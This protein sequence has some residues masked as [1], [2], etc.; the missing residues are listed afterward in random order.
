MNRRLV[1]LADRQ[2]RFGQFGANLG[3]IAFGERENLFIQLHH[4][5]VVF[6]GFAL[7]DGAFQVAPFCHAQVALGKHIA[8]ALFNFKAAE[9]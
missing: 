8:Q 3:G 4:A 2:A 7:D 5:G 6:G 1:G 9:E